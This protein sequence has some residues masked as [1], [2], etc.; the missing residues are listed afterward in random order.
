MIL[1][2]RGG[3][4]LACSQSSCGPSPMQHP[5]FC[6]TVHYPDDALDHAV[7]AAAPPV[8]IS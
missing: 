5:L 2:P 6:T 8:T 4:S 1:Q 3:W 7:A